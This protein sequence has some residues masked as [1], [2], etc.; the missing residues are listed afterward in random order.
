MMPLQGHIA[1]RHMKTKLSRFSNTARF[2]V[3]V[4]LLLS[5]SIPIRETVRKRQGGREAGKNK[6]I[7]VDTMKVCEMSRNAVPV[8]LNTSTGAWSVSRPQVIY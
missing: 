7:P 8:I 6:A 1:Q 5:F 2:K 3:R 4:N